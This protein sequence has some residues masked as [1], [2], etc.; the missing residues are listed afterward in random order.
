MRG[1]RDIAFRPVRFFKIHS[2]SVF[3]IVLG[4]VIIQSMTKVVN[5][6]FAP[7]PKLSFR[8]LENMYSS[9]S[10]FSVAGVEHP[11]GSELSSQKLLWLLFVSVSLH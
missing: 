11:F 3:D 6:G 8:A 7:I 9:P 10:P 4:A 2:H 5:S 1:T